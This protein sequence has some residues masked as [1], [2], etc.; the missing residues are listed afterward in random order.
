MNIRRFIAYLLCLSLLLTAFTLVS[1]D[2]TIADET[3]EVSTEKA[4]EVTTEAETSAPVGDVV[5]Y[6]VKISSEGKFLLDE[7]EF[8]VYADRECT[9]LRARGETNSKG[10]GKFKLPETTY[11]LKLKSAPDGYQYEELYE[12]TNT[13]TSITLKSYIRDNAPASNF[14]YQTG[15]VIHN[16]ILSGEGEGAI[17]VADALEQYNCIV[18]NFWYIGCGPCKAEFPYIQ[19]AYEKYSDKVGFFALNGNPAESNQDIANFMSQNGYTFK[20][21]RADN[22][23]INYFGIVGFPTTIIIDKYGVICLM[24][25]GSVPEEA[26]F[27]NAFAHFT[28]DSYSETT[29]FDS[30]HDIGT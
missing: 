27:V 15:D 2:D 16:F 20:T 10:E 14:R 30:L 25:T 18:L 11:Y 6:S 23:I 3:T 29:I 12:I 28:S 22:A 9:S 4:T 13:S 21:G 1:C 5:E 24:E 19:S 26:P 8:E 17:T 7:V